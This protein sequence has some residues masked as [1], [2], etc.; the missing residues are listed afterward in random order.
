MDRHKAAWV[1]VGVM[2]D[3]AVVVTAVLVMLPLLR[4]R[5]DSFFSGFLDVLMRNAVVGVCLL[6]VHGT[7]LP[8]FV[9]TQRPVSVKDVAYA[10]IVSASGLVVLGIGALLVLLVGGGLLTGRAPSSSQV[11]NVALLGF[12]FVGGHIALGAVSLALAMNMAGWR[13]DRCWVQVS[14]GW[15]GGA[16]GGALLAGTMLAGAWTLQHGVRISW[17]CWLAG[18]PHLLLSA[19]HLPTDMAPLPIALRR[20]AV[21]LGLML[22]VVLLVLTL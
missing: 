15:L 21:A 9:W 8:G 16:A 7:V 18:L 6:V 11:V 10:G 1:G 3:A 17:F 13:E 22:A 14:S 20:T 5:P 12:V 4:F 19:R 2:L